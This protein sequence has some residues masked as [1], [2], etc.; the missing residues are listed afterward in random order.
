[1]LR[2]EIVGVEDGDIPLYFARRYKGI[3]GLHPQRARRK[4]TLGSFHNRRSKI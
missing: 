1:M 2:N 4:G 3:F